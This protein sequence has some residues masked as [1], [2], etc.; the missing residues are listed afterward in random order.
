MLEKKTLCLIA[1]RLWKPWHTGDPDLVRA[2]SKD[3]RV[4]YRKMP[5][6][7][8]FVLWCWWRHWWQWWWPERPWPDLGKR[9][10]PGEISQGWSFNSCGSSVQTELIIRSKLWTN[11]SPSHSW[12][13][14]RTLAP[15]SSLVEIGKL[16]MEEVC[17]HSRGISWGSSRSRSNSWR[18]ILT[19]WM[20][21]CCK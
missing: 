13:R 21:A 8:S 12:R 20:C 17:Q 19:Y 11:I 2:G 7:W 3:R 16:G 18:L 9:M 5:S 4:L 15:G 6:F 10:H 1:S 14:V